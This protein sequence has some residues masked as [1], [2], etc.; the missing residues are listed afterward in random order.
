MDTN[1]EKEK[2]RSELLVNKLIETVQDGEQAV[3]F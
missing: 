3:S 2:T 1:G